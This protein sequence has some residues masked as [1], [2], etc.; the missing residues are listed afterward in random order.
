M[1]A[2]FREVLKIVSQ[3][4]SSGELSSRSSTFL[5]PVSSERKINVPKISLSSWS[6]AGIAQYSTASESEVEGFYGEA[7]SS[8]PGAGDTTGAGWRYNSGKN[9]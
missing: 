8:W 4:E 2:Q 6:R 3:V 7:G 5:A 9:C 1:V